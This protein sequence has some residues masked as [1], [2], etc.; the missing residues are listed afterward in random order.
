MDVLEDEWYKLEPEK[1]TKLI[2]SM[3]KKVKAVIKSKGNPT[4]Y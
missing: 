2:D 4:K 3:P 1:L